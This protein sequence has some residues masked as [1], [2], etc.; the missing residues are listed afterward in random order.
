MIVV[1]IIL[2]IVHFIVWGITGIIDD[3]VYKQTGL[4]AMFVLVISLIFKEENETLLS[5]TLLFSPLLSTGWFSCVFCLLL[6]V[7]FKVETVDGLEV[8]DFLRGSYTYVF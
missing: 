7:V 5:D 6:V 2:F 1:T 8:T 3:A 4:V